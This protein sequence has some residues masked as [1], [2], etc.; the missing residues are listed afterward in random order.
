[1]QIGCTVKD[2]LFTLSMLQSEEVCNSNSLNPKDE[3]EQ[4]K[5]MSK[6]KHEKYLRNQPLKAIDLYR[7]VHQPKET[8]SRS[9]ISES[10]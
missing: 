6:N 10:F 9:K 8:K 4:N 3:S 1:M 7:Q 2:W 5:F